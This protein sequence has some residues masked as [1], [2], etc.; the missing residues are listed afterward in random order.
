[1]SR[2]KTY[3]SVDEITNNLYASDKQLMYTDGTIYAAR[4]NRN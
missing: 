1:M 3:Y 4:K 2:E